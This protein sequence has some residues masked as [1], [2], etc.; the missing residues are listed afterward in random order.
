MWSGIAVQA[1]ESDQNPNHQISA[2]KYAER[3]EAL[4]K[5]QGQT[6]QDTYKAYDWTQ[7][8]IDQRQA[9]IDRRHE[10]RMAY[11]NRPF[12]SQRPY[13]NYGNYG[14]QQYGYNNNNYGYGNYNNYGYSS[15]YLNNS[16]SSLLGMGLGYY[17]FH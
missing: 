3:S 13:R 16:C 10:L 8:K 6:V 15:G 11:A 5:N 7:N 9:R 4:L 14:N 1:Q 2:T 12:Y 17:L